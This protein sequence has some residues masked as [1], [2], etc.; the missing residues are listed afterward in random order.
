VANTV[1]HARPVF[2][3]IATASK[4]PVAECAANAWGISNWWYLW[5]TRGLPVAH[6][7]FWQRCSTSL[8]VNY[9]LCSTIDYSGYLVTETREAADRDQMENAQEPSQRNRTAMLSV[10]NFLD[11]EQYRQQRRLAD[12]PFSAQTGAEAV[13]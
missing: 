6:S 4:L 9:L 3:A 11:E 12:N 13:R 2:A 1:T 7:A 8:R 10:G 5:C